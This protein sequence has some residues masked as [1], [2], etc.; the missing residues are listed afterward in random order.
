[1]TEFLDICYDA[2][3]MQEKSIPKTIA[4]VDESSVSV[5]ENKRQIVLVGCGDSYAAAD[6]GRWTFLNI[7]LNALF[8]SPDEIRHLRL[9]KESVV[10]G[11]TASG[12]SLATIDALQKAK[13]QGATI[14]VLTDNA[15]GMAS[16]EADHVWVTK[17]GVGTYN[18]SPS[19]PTTAAMVYLLG[20]SSKLGAAD[21]LDHDIQQLK[22]VGKEML[23]WAEQKGKVISQLTKPD[24]PIYLISEGPN[25][26]A[27]Q[28]GMMKFNE[29]SILK[30]IAAIREDFSHH[31]NLA[32]KE[33]DGGVLISS[34]PTNSTDDAYAKVLTDTLKMKAYHLYTDEKLNLELPLVQAIPNMI[35]LQMAS[36]HTV[37]KFDPDKESFK[38]SHAEAFKIY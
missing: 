7:G 19:A 9:D 24:V 20:I 30:G 10:I 23:T 6:Y 33:N 14:V 25:H 28:I 3:K 27:A 36:Y 4:A 13:S 15:E 31:Y 11:I 29:F 16:E 2:I 17:S 12:R 18:T 22:S 5:L 34:S 8:V 26:V 37:L 32:I 21:R 35:A 38:Q 1:M